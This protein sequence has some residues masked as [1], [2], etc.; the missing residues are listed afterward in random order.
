MNTGITASIKA[1]L[2]NRVKERGVEF[3]FVL[4]RY[5]C[6]RLLYRLGASR[7]RERC[8]TSDMREESTQ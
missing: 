6:E 4:V 8:S 7:V 2:L 5:A 1:R 3:Q